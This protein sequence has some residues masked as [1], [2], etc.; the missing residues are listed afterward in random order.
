MTPA[1]RGHNEKTHGENTPKTNRRP[2][3]PDGPDPCRPAAR[4]ADLGA[5]E[6][7]RQV[8]ID[9]SQLRRFASG[10]RQLTTGEKLDRLIDWLG[11][12]VSYGHG[13]R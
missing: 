7:G 5:R 10:E 13:E 9:H 4:L 6:C 12:D 8:D 1:P 2:T 3:W 11:I